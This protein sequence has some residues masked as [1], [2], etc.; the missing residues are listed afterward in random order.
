M[1]SEH[2]SPLAA[3]GEVDAGGQNVHVAE[4]SSAMARAGHDVTVYTR[5]DGSHLQDEVVT[6]QGY[7]VVHVP[8]GPEEHVPKDAL[9]PHMGRFTRYLRRRWRD[10]PP[11]VVHSHFWMSGLATVF[12]CRAT[13]VPVVHTYHALGTVKRRHQGDADTSPEE[14]IGYERLVGRAAAAIVATCTDEVAELTAMG[15]DA[16]KAAVVPCGVDCGRFGLAAE[17]VRKRREHRVVAVGRLV[18]RKGFADL[19][20][21]LA[22]CRDTELVIAG[23]PDRARLATDAE[24]QRLTGLARDLGVADRVLLTGRVGRN[25]MP[26]LLR[27]ADVVACV[28]WYEPFG[29]VPLEAMA[30]GVPVV[31]TAVGGLTD[32]VVDGVTGVLV[33]PRQPAALAEAVRALLADPS[34]RALLGAAGRERVESRYTWDRI[35]EETLRVYA[36]CTDRTLVGAR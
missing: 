7:R 28:P 20:E 25:R 26:A 11:D 33:P 34:R 27:S 22:Q 24:A 6:P 13:E 3:L 14:R 36:R 18:P 15:I 21:M 35:A 9:L 12:A 8:A 5:K 32:T 2:A 29:I 23:G 19:V 1:I 30:C 4:L 16:A 17:P 31:A 10:D